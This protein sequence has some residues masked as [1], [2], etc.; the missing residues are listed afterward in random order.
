MAGSSSASP[1]ARRARAMDL[2]RCTRHMN[3]HDL[4]SAD[5]RLLVLEMAVAA[6][7][8]QQPPSGPGGA[9]RPAVLHRRRD[10]G[11]RGRRLECRGTAAGPC[12]PLGERDAPARH[13]IASRRAPTRQPPH[14]CR[15]LD[16]VRAT[17]DPRRPASP[18]RACLAWS[19]AALAA[20]AGM[21]RHHRARPC[22]WRLVPACDGPDAGPRLRV[23]GDPREA[24][25]QLNDGR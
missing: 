4:S 25:P 21:Q 18:M 22:G 11:S 15:V 7:I 10:R 5:A 23:A 13:G 8:A 9:G 2:G 6:L 12:P 24:A 3:D 20:F 1:R 16:P 17:R 19:Q 14:L